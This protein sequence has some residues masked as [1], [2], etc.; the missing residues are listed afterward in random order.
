MPVAAI[1]SSVCNP[2]WRS[3]AVRL[4]WQPGYGGVLDQVNN[5]ASMSNYSDRQVPFTGCS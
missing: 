1:G 3:V 2:L 5:I 4:R